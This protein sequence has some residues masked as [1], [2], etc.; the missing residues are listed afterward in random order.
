MK[1]QLWGLNPTEVKIVL[2]VCLSA[3]EDT[4]VSSRR[5]GDYFCGAI[6]KTDDE[7]NYLHHWYVLGKNGQLVKEGEYVFGLG[8][9]A[10]HIV[11]DGAEYWPSQEDENKNYISVVV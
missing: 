3:T 6:R 7:G 9:S 1:R 2:K 11:K 10:R 5:F 8:Q 4:H